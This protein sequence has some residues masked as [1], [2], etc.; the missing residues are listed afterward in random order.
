MASI[1]NPIRPK[2]KSTSWFF[3]VLILMLIGFP[4]M[5]FAFSPLSVMPAE[6]HCGQIIVSLD[7]NHKEAAQQ[8][9]D[10]EQLATLLKKIPR[11][12]R[13]L[14]KKIVGE[15]ETMHVQFQVY[16]NTEEAEPKM[17]TL[18]FYA[19]ASADAPT[20]YLD[21]GSFS[22][23]ISNAAALEAQLRTMCCP[24]ETAAA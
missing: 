2:K 5:Q 17:Y 20:G 22:Y 1:E 7:G 23:R 24:A 14:E 9:I 19:A 13:P 18:R 6:S 12:R 8:V 21:I 11:D 15:T 10:A 16:S 4:F 3:P